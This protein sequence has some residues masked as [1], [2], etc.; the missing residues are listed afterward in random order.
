MIHKKILD[1][2]KT[3]RGDNY[4]FLH[5]DKFFLSSPFK[6]FPRWKSVDLKISRSFNHRNLRI[7]ESG[8]SKVTTQK[9]TKLCNNP[10]HRVSRLA[11]IFSTSLLS[12]SLCLS[13]PIIIIALILLFFPFFSFIMPNLLEDHPPIVLF[14]VYREMRD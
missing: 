13:L 8:E 12:L 1:K 11:R 5:E 9:L 7:F 4:Q 6:Y 2:T 14:V 10:Q 3:L